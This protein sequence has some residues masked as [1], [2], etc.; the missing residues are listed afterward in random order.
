MK[1]Q[2]A[3]YASDVTFNVF[4][5]QLQCDGPYS[6]SKS[7]SIYW[8][9]KRLSTVIDPSFRRTMLEQLQI[10]IRAFSFCLFLQLFSVA[11]FPSSC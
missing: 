7:L 4:F 11:A 3:A 6:P 8:R 5:Q 10:F 1:R 9:V 2:S